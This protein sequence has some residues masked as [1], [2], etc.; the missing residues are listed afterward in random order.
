MG[1]I[2]DRKDKQIL[3]F[4]V[5]FKKDHNQES[6]SIK[7]IAGA[8]KL[9]SSSSDSSTSDEKMDFITLVDNVF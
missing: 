3:Q 2:L 7:E 9:N 4:I 6:P 8:I 1:V 5:D